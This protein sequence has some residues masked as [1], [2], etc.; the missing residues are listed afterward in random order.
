MSIQGR[1]TDSGTGSAHRY[2]P[3]LLPHRRPYRLTNRAA[4]A[5][6]ASQAQEAPSPPGREF[7]SRTALTDRY[8][9]TLE[10]KSSLE[11]THHTGTHAPRSNITGGIPP[12]HFSHSRAASAPPP[13]LPTCREPASLSFPSACRPTPG[14]QTSPLRACPASLTVCH[15]SAPSSHP[16]PCPSFC[17]K[18][19]FRE[20]HWLDECR[21]IHRVGQQNKGNVITQTSNIIKAMANDVLNWNGHSRLGM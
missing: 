14:H 10:Q 21:V 19:P 18:I 13:P 4:L 7:Q 16:A 6:P 11:R 17:F 9:I 8:L 12:S 5:R 2:E 15:L 3:S 1:V 20:T